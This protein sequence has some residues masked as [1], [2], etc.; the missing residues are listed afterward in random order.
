MLCYVFVLLHNALT[1]LR[2]A[3]A[4]LIY[5]SGH[6]GT[7]I[8]SHSYFSKLIDQRYCFNS[9]SLFHYYVPAFHFFKFF[10]EPTRGISKFFLQNPWGYP[11]MFLPNSL[12]ILFIYTLTTRFS[13]KSCRHLALQSNSHNVIT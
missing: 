3:I 5:H 2:S 8:A 4:S 1:L 13:I 7:M 6:I 12:F 10:E 9:L 11:K